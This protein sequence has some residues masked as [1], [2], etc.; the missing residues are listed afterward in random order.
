LE[1]KGKKV[2]VVGLGKSGAAAARLCLDRG[3]RVIATDQAPDPQGA[4]GLAAAGA[5]LHLA[6]HRPEDFTWAEVVVLSPGV[7]QRLPEVA[8][9]REHGAE[10]LGEL[11]LAGAFGRRPR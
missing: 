8:A 1:L 7:D 11:E 4:A 6:G 5:E 3:A 2:L 9:A 10:V